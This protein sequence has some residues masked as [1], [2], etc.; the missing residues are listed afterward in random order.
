MNNQRNNQNRK[1]RSN[2][3]RK[4]ELIV[5]QIIGS[6]SDIKAILKITH[7]YIKIKINST[8]IFF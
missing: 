7:L 2:E 8:S 5:L 3:K 1:Y 4:G 6:I